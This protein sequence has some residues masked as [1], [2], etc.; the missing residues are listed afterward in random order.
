LLKEKFKELKGVKERQEPIET[1]LSIVSDRLTNFEKE[2]AHIKNRLREI[3]ALKRE[4]SDLGNAEQKMNKML[5]Q[6]QDKLEGSGIEKSKLENKIET[7][8]GKLFLL[9]KSQQDIKDTLAILREHNKKIEM[10]LLELKNSK[11]DLQD[12][13]EL[14]L[15]LESAL[16]KNADVVET[17][18]EKIGG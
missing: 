18:L 14:N 7:V 10:G 15:F 12:I 9:E 8:S 11:A 6:Y 2:Y 1:S 3:I 13:K 5:E 17:M 16:R 4:L